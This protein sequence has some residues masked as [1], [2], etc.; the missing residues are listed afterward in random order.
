MS[1]RKNPVVPSKRVTNKRA[2][3]PLLFG[4]PP[5]IEGEDAG[6]YDDFLTRISSAVKP[7]DFLEEIWVRDVVDLS[8]EVLRMRR[9]KAD[10]ITSARS[11]GLHDHDLSISIDT[12]ERIDRMTTG[13]E[14]RRNDALREI[15]RH[16]S[17][18][19]EELR[20]ATEDVVDAE[21]VD[22]PRVESD[23]E[24]DEAVAR[25]EFGAERDD[26]V[27]PDDDRWGDEA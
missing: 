18:L 3:R 24:P 7:K 15:E 27:A 11:R 4:L 17:S 12:V 26:D 20:R 19:A 21:F 22:I 1:R 14:R 9:V 8:W 23:R 5:L 25:V 16:R 13:A 2:E 6:T 10:V